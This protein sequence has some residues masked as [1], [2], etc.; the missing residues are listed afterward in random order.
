MN[1]RGRYTCDGVK[2]IAR[3]GRRRWRYIEY[4]R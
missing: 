3:D 4:A 1:A 2:V